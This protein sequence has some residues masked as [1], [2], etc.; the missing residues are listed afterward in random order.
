MLR[1]PARK[2]PLPSDAV[3]RARA[4]LED[5]RRARSEPTT[6]QWTTSSVRARGERQLVTFEPS[7]AGIPI[8]QRRA[9]VLLGKSGRPSVLSEI[10][11]AGGPRGAFQLSGH[12]AAQ[13]A[14]SHQR[15]EGAAR[16]RAAGVGADGFERFELAKSSPSGPSLLGPIRVSRVYF[17]APDALLPAYSVVVGSVGSQGSG[18]RRGEEVL[19][20]ADSGEILAAR[21]TIASAHSYRVWTADEAGTP[22]EGPLTSLLPYPSATPSGAN[23]LPV[24]SKLIEVEGFNSPAGG[25]PDPWLPESATTTQGNNVDAYVDFLDPN[26][27][28]GTGPGPGEFRAD[29]TAPGVFDYSFDLEAEPLQSDA[30][31]SAAIVQAFYTANWL[32][33]WYYD[34]GF[35]EVSRN[36]QAQNYGRGGF[37][38]DVLH[39][40]VQDGA[41]GG[42][43][44]RNNANM[45]T[46][47]DGVSPVMQ[48]YV[49]SAV[50][51]SAV[52]ATPGGL[53]PSRVAAFGPT[54]FSVSGPLVAVNDGTADTMDG[55]QTITQNLTGSVA[56]LRR[57]SCPFVQKAD[58]ATAAGAIGVLIADNAPGTPPVMD[59]VSG[60]ASPTLSTTQAAGDALVA[61][62][63][64]GAVTVELYRSASVERDGA[65]D[66]TIVA[67]EW[68]HY[69]Q[70][71]LAPCWPTEIVN[72]VPNPSQCHAMGEGGGDFIALH[73]LL[74]EDDDPALPYPMAA[75]A[76]AALTPDL[77]FGLRRVPYSTSLDI[78][79]LTFRHI[80]DGEELPVDPPSYPSGAPNSEVHNA[81]EVWTAMLFEVYA[82]LQAEAAQA[83]D[84][85][86]FQDVRREMSDDLVLALSMMPYERTLL[87]ARDVLLAAIAARSETDAV[88]AAA[89]F[90]K[91]GAG[92]CAEGP[93]FDSTTNLGVVEDF[94]LAP[95]LELGAVSAQDVACDNGE[96]GVLDAGE[97]GAIVV[98][99]DNLG[100]GAAGAT[101]VTLSDLP[102]ELEELEGAELTLD[103]I[104]PLG[105]AL[106]EFPITLGTISGILTAPITVTL[107]SAG[108]CAPLGAESREIALNFDDDPAGSLS[109]DFS[110][111]EGGWSLE[112]A[113]AENVWSRSGEGE[114]ALWFGQDYPSSSNSA[115]V[116]P[117][118]QV[119]PTEPFTVTLTHRYSFEVTLDEHWD[120]GVIEVSVDDGATWVDVS[121][122]EGVDPSYSGEITEQTDNPLTAETGLARPAFVGVSAAY[123]SFAPLVLDFGT[124]LAG[125]TIRLA[126]R[127]GTDQLQGAPGWAL[128]DIAFSGVV[129]GPFPSRL[130]D[131]TPAEPCPEPPASGGSGGTD[132]GGTTA[133]GSGGQASSASGGATLAGSGGTGATTGSGGTA[134]AEAPGGCGCRV[135]GGPSVSPGATLLGLVGLLLLGRRRQRLV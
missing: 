48:I 17:P 92:S 2:G 117:P 79:P 49:W 80:A 14:W 74:A 51:Q 3:E 47:P 128:D 110:T 130:A 106:A 59:G 119:S 107:E 93:P 5:A 97:S 127:I 102:T 45:Y 123:P 53:Y 118:I 22:A 61:A 68:G 29:V 38:G 30:Q 32:H 99:V 82:A 115:L 28:E 75:Y 90:A 31:A 1:A 125:E 70:D 108:T 56:L 87:D 13:V 39:L 27:A 54:I 95:R 35:D 112:G 37:E 101:T 133:E 129:Q 81:G 98:E 86:T 78:S 83:D 69:L 40:H 16:L 58:A 122:F 63:A 100:H 120:G 89:A 6:A 55:C 77:Y 84:P 126:F 57:G 50:A 131:E 42:Q 135:T 85:R 20:S 121:E 24:P 26:N 43:P 18:D 36:A 41:Q 91:R 10:P 12:A 111:D 103:S 23:P 116:S 64:S 96:D 8:W 88:A 9:T 71:R 134:P 25:T 15:P 105:T 19:V 104:P 46:P 73:M 113:K 114:S 21:S 65:L 72:Q 52:E 76:A 44:A 132:A 60:T 34:S 11:T 67:H 124:E 33:D 7:F 62:L 109:D 94:E 4:T 66:G